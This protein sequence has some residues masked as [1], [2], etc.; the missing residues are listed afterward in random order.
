[1]IS[2]RLR[3]SRTVISAYCASRTVSS[4]D[5]SPN[6]LGPVCES[7]V[8]PR[9]YGVRSCSHCNGKPVERRGRK[10]T[11][12]RFASTSYDGRVASA[13]KARLSRFPTGVQSAP[14]LVFLH[15]PSVPAAIDS[16]AYGRGVARSIGPMRSLLREAYAMRSTTSPIRGT[17]N[18]KFHVTAVQPSRGPTKLVGTLMV[19]ACLWGLI[20]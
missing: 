5:L 3:H 18:N 12:L 10:P 1:M 6:P 9:H 8:S 11:D 19:A 7:V 17:R 14:S 2:V 16:L 13:E 4:P 20:L 15:G